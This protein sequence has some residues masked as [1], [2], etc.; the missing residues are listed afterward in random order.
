MVGAR[1][2]VGL[3]LPFDNMDAI[4]NVAICPHGLTDVW[5]CPLYKLAVAYGGSAAAAAALPKAA[6][7]GVFLA[8]S[9]C[10]LGVVVGVIALA[11]LVSVSAAKAVLV[12]HMLWVHLPAHYA[13]ANM[14]VAHT[15][16]LLAFGVLLEAIAFRPLQWP[17]VTT[18]LVAGHVAVG[19]WT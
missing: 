5:G 19:L 12:A 16:V 18:G 8:I 3:A 4:I 2:Q 9:A 11:G 1:K 10:H 7:L 14:T 17:R 13:D 6:V 15:A